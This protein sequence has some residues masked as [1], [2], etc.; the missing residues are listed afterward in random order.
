M[1]AEINYV[2][3][4]PPAG[5]A[6]LEYVTEAEERNTMVT[7]PGRPVEISDGRGLVTDLDREGF[8]LVTHESA[9]ADF[10]LIQEDP[11]VDTQYGDETAA[12]LTE[13]TGAAR[14]LMLGGG[15][16]RYGESA[17]DRLAPLSNAKPARYPHADNTDGSAAELANLFDMFVDDFDLGAYP[18]YAMYNV[19][20]AFSPP[21]QDFPLAVCDAQTLSLDDEVTVTAITEERKSDIVHDTTSYVYNPAHRWYYFPDMT[22]DEVIVFKSHDSDPIAARRVAHTAFTDPTCPSGVPTRASVEMRAL[23]V[24]D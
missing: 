20:R 22:R 11:A 8:M 13:L 5:G 15:K 10:H 23:A 14:V 4:P 2:R 1:E 21:P 7:L 9:V 12:M 19:W 18:R 6:V 16:K 24:F 3:N 17:V